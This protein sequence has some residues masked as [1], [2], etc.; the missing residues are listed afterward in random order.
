MDSNDLER[1]RGI[2]ILAK[3]TSVVWNDTASTSSTRPATPTSA[4][5]S[6]AS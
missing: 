3:A 2:T 1:E 5:R 4:A 6:S